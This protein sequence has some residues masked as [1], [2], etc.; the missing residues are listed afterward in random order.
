MNRKKEEKEVYV[1]IRS[2]NIGFKFKASPKWIQ[3][4]RSEYKKLNINS[5][6]LYLFNIDNL[7]T[8]SIMFVGFA[9]DKNFDSNYHANIKRLP[10]DVKVIFDEDYLIQDLKN[11][12]LHLKILRNYYSPSF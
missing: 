5:N 7:T 4:K 12:L 10:D 11:N 1:D 9:S 2:K 6:T 3:V 8:L